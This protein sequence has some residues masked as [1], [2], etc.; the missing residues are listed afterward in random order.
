MRGRPCQSRY[1]HLWKEKAKEGEQHFYSDQLDTSKVPRKST[2][3]VKPS[4]IY[5]SVDIAP[6]NVLQSTVLKRW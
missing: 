5:L 2:R 4:F 6:E 3:Y 1:V